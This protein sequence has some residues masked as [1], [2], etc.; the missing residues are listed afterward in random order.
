LRLDEIRVVSG[1]AL[2]CSDAPPKTFVGQRT[3]FDV[4]GKALD[5]DTRPGSDEA[6]AAHILGHARERAVLQRLH[7]SRSLKQIGPSLGDTAYA[8]EVGAIVTVPKP[9]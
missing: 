5:A 2:G 9:S 3:G 7:P 1:A 4:V 8:D 6:D